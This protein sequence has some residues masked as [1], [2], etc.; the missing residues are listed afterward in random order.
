M[1]YSHSHTS[2]IRVLRDAK[3]QP[4]K[5]RIREVGIVPRVTALYVKCLA[6]THQEDVIFV[7]F[8]LCILG[9]I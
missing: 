3:F 1:L 9:R 7:V 4:Q 5:P 6:I 2:L 8:V